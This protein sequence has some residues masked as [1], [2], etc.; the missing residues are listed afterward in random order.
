LSRVERDSLGSLEL[1]DAAL[2][3]IQ[4]A[5]ALANFPVSGLRAHPE[6][7]SAYLFVKKAAVLTNMELKVLD[8]A[9]GSAILQAADDALT[10]KFNDQ[11]VVDAYQAGAG[12]SFNMNVNEVLANRALELLGRKRGDYEYL[13][14]ND[15]VN[16]GQSSNDTYPTASHVATIMAA[17]KL[18]DALEEL[19]LVFRRKGD[20]FKAIPKVGR[21]HLMDALP[22]TLGD[23]FRAYA[24]ALERGAQRIEQRRDDLRE[25]PI[26]GTAVGTGAGSHRQFRDRIIQHLSELCA[27]EFIPARDSF[28]AL[29]SRALLSAF[30]SAL[31]ELALELIRI[32]N[33][34]RLLA[35]GPFAGLAEIELPVVQ[36][37][38]SIMPG[39]VNPSMPECL[40]MICFQVVGNDTAVALAVQAGQLELNVMAPVITWNILQ[41]LTLLAN[42]LPVFGVSC[43]EGVRAN[44][45]KCRAY[46]ELNPALATLLVPKIG[47]LQAAELAKE[48]VARKMPVPE[49]AVEKGILTPEEAAGLFDLKRIISREGVAPGER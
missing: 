25:L 9:L 36:P 28:E 32:A 29:Q 48:A 27:I 3:G 49:L 42:F 30:S 4:T 15:H 17:V 44:E 34:L 2:Y 23:E 24:S 13:S 20:E 21:T 6:L 33:D 11:F 5:R 14:P 39:K 19:A 31:K 18:L 43:V 8:R 38:S 12:T 22:V 7:V 35:S 45:E 10:G 47:H 40:N 16:L 41:S 37:G 26:G 46:L 1:P